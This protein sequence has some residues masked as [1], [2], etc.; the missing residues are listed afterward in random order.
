MMIGTAAAASSPPPKDHPTPS[1][2]KLT[3]PGWVTP[4]PILPPGSNDS[5]RLARREANHHVYHCNGNQITWYHYVLFD[6]YIYIY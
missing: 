4:P 6:Y 1:L 2:P 3:S 5:E